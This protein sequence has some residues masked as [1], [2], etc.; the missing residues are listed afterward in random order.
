VVR[1]GQRL[2]GDGEKMVKM[3]K[4]GKIKKI[5]RNHFAMERIEGEGIE[6]EG[7]H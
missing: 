1:S 4:M 2:D 7:I 5:E 6:V 3:E